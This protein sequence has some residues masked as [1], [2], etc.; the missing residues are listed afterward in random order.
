MN[1]HYTANTFLYTSLTEQSGDVAP[2][3]GAAE[4][5]INHDELE[6]TTY[7]GMKHSNLQA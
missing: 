3:V 2:V 1:H 6:W 7:E 5:I 4:R